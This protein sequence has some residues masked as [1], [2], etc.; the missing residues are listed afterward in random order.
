[1]EKLE[2][3]AQSITWHVTSARW[4]V[5][6]EVAAVEYLMATLG[7]DRFLPPI[8]GWSVDYSVV[9]AVLDGALA[10]GGPVH[11]LELGSGAGTPWFASV[12]KLTG[13]QHVAVEHNPVFVARTMALLEHYELL[14]FCTVVEAEL[15]PGADGAEWYALAPIT[16]RV[17]DGSV[18]VLVIDGPPASVGPQ[19]RRPALALLERL[20]ADDALVVL[21]DVVRAEEQ[22]TLAAWEQEYGDR[23]RVLPILDR[24]A[25]FRLRSAAPSEGPQ[26][27]DEPDPTEEA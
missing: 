9:A 26:S 23:L 19:A 20:L 7:S 1:M 2:T 14:D 16:S 21:D 13:G 24:A 17:S 10:R 15:T 4:Q 25:L 11:S 3:A 12:A 27:G 18:D 5:A 8:G 6:R 22:Q